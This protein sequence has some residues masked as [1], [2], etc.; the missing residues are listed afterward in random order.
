[1]AQEDIER[2]VELAWLN[3]FYGALLT[4]KQ[5]QV[6]MLHCEEDLSLGEIG[7]ETGISRQGVHECLTGAARRLRELEN[8]LGMAERFRRLSDGL[9]ECK[10]ALEH[11]E[12]DK[13]N[14]LIDTLIHLNEEESY[15]L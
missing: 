4:D 13:A 9:Q 3:A 2:K 10:A 14:S 6:L 11:Q 15:G 12:Y 8:L 1:M 5:R 7:K